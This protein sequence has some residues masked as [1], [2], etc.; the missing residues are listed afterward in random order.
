[1]GT[2]SLLRQIGSLYISPAATTVAAHLGFSLG[3]DR[4]GCALCGVGAE[5]GVGSLV[6]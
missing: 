1:M 5:G 2:E 4:E 6:G 3:L